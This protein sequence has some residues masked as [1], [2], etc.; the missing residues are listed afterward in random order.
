[1]EALWKALKGD[2]DGSFGRN[3][4][5]H[6]LPFKKPCLAPAAPPYVTPNYKDR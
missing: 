1:M 2:L 5:T 3:A 4:G 6:P